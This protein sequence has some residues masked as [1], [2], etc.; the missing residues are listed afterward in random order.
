MNLWSKIWPPLLGVALGLGFLI[1][2][3]TLTA[4]ADME[5]VPKEEQCDPEI[6][7]SLMPDGKIRTTITMCDG[8][9]VRHQS[10]LSVCGVST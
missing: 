8:R 10:V 3:G 9:K 6:V 7:L 2:F 4:V 1:A 5:A